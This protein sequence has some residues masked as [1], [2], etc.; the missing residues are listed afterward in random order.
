MRLALILGEPIKRRGTANLPPRI[1]SMSSSFSPP[2]SCPTRPASY[3]S[4]TSVSSPSSR[5]HY[6]AG[7]FA[8]IFETPSS[9]GDHIL[10]ASPGIDDH[11]H[12]KLVSSRR[13]S[14]IERLDSERGSVRPCVVLYDCPDGEHPFVFLCGRFGGSSYEK[15]PY[16]YKHFVTAIAPH[17]LPDGSTPATTSPPWQR[18]NAMLLKFGIQSTRQ[19]QGLWRRN[20]EGELEEGDV[21]GFQLSRETLDLLQVEAAAALKSWI[22]L[23]IDPSFLPHVAAEYNVCTLSP[24]SRCLRSHS[25]I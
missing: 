2:L 11:P 24:T 17:N 4:R 10:L 1:C 12:I 7:Q 9:V 13:I 6:H 3:L 15:L 5:R 8:R 19:L 16:L 23:C 21:C 14:S 20:G 25:T 18:H 22:A